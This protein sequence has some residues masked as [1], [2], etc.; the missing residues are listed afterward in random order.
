MTATFAQMRRQLGEAGENLQF[1]SITIDPEY[2]R[3]DHLREYAELFH[4]GPGW[5]FLTGDGVAISEVLRS[6]DAYTG[7]KM[8]HQPLTLLKEPQNP[9]WVRIDG[10]AGSS[11][12]A[13]EVT[14]RLLN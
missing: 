5:T 1:V 9:F 12:L 6:F 13:A 2:D 11:D 14:A 3:P 7:T 10:L 4:A 8:N